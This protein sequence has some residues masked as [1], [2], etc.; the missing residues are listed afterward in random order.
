[1]VNKRGWIRILE[2]TIAVLIVSSVLIMI[3]SG[4]PE[5][6]DLSEEISSLQKSILNEISSDNNLRSHVL[7]SEVGSN[8]EMLVQHIEG[9]IPSQLN[10]SLKICSLSEASCKLDEDI[11]KTLVDK[12][13]FVEEIIISTDLSTYNPKKVRLFVW[14]I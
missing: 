13:V 12:E 2:A 3:Y 14:M 11:F 10:F 9:K 5:R 8:Y 4:H 6:V 7:N 1:M